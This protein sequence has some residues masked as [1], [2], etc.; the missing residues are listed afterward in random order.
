M[1]IFLMISFLLISG[2]TFLTAQT[3]DTARVFKEMNDLQKK[4]RE[5]AVSFNVSYSYASELHPGVILD[6]LTGKMDL[7]GSKYHYLVD[8]TETISNGRYNIIL[9]GDDK[10]MYLAKPA[11]LS[12]GDPAAQ[13]RLMMEQ[14]GIEK[15]IITE[16]GNRKSLL[17]SFLPGSSYRE[18]E[19]IIDKASGYLTE[20]RYVVKT[21]LLMESKGTTPDPEYGEYAIVRTVLDNYK[22][23]AEDISRFD[24]HTFFYKDGNEFKTTP[25]YQ[26]Y[27]I[28]VGS[29]NL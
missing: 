25:A 6:S 2:H 10:I 5:Q 22:K 12:T 21:A 20:T 11:D 29:P 9:Y 17:V 13:L 3:V 18:V 27:K 15:C 28:F 14:S 26:E 24:E 1:R 19:M 8:N 4:Y 7:D 16:K 23:L